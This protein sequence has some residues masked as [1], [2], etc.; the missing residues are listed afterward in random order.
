MIVVSILQG[1]A[2]GFLLAAPIG[3]IGILCVRGSLLYGTRR[4]FVIGLSGACGDALYAFAAAFGVQL[5]VNF[6]SSHL[7]LMR[8]LGGIL[9]VCTGIYTFLSQPKAKHPVNIKIGERGIF[10]STLLLALTNPLTLFAYLSAFAATGV[11]NIIDDHLTISLLI[12]GVFGGSLLWFSLLV[13]LSQRF[14]EK[15]SSRGI[16][17]INKTAG[18]LLIVFGTI[19]ASYGLRSFW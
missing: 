6:V 18:A 10:V 16:L 7:P 17:I 11:N 1:I 12:C 19:A 9:L 2:I 8:L 13:W 5:I 3:P 15:V 14:K 4:G